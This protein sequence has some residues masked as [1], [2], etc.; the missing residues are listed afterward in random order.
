MADSK[1][2]TDFVDVYRGKTVAIGTVTYGRH[3][4]KVPVS[5]QGTSILRT[6]NGKITDCAD[7]YDGLTSPRI[8]VTSYFREWTELCR[9]CF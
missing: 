6:K 1:V 7:Y 2:D 4:W 9:E 8:V 3:T 5:F